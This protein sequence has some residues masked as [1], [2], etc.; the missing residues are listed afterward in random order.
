MNQIEIFK[1]SITVL[2]TETTN[3]LPESCEIVEVAGTTWDGRWRTKST[4]LGAQNG[5]PAEA[6]AKNNIS[7]RLIANLPTFKND[8]SNIKVILN[9]PSSK[10]YIAHN[11]EYD[12][13]A[14][15]HAFSQA[16][17]IA[18]CED[19]SRWICTWRLSKQILK[20][21][22]NDIQ[23][24]LNY[25]RYKLD[26]QIDDNIG[27]HRAAADTLVTATLLDKLIEIA[28]RNNQV[29]PAEN[30]GIQLN[31][32]CLDN[33]LVKIWPFGKKH[34]GQLLEELDN[35]YFLWALK[36]LPQLDESNSLYDADLTES[37]RQ[38]LEKRLD[39]E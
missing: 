36:N 29:N 4:L 11:A 35:D 5:I 25:L 33:I 31:K 22:F 9:W 8:I 3:L 37:V 38:L 16:T 34:R 6:S 14:L 30:I 28:I 7:N 13:T 27:V 12:R 39:T 32:L 10:W 20:H 26:L 23:Y 17:D 21:E 15:K 2:D 24:G 19:Q 18:L 1:N